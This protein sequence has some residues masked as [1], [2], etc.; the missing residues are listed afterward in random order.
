[1]GHDRVG[2]SQ[3]TPR[4]DAA[5][6]FTSGMAGANGPA[7]V[8]VQAGQL[9][10]GAFDPIEAIV[11]EVRARNAWVLD[12]TFGLWRSSRASARPKWI[13]QP[14]AQLARQS[15]ASRLMA[16]ALPRALA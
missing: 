8:I 2:V 9:N 5:P 3:P 15:C 10:T 12:G 11:P 16:P 14:T 6:A 7:I 1:M 4:P 13:R